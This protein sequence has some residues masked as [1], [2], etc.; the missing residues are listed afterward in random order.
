MYGPRID[1]VV[2]VFLFTCAAVMLLVPAPAVSAQE[3][4]DAPSEATGDWIRLESARAG[5]STA[6]QAEI[7]IIYAQ[8][9][10]R[11]PAL[12]RT[13]LERIR[14]LVEEN[15]PVSRFPEVVEVISFIALE[16]HKRRTAG[17]G[18]PPPREWSQAPVRIEAV[19]LL[20][21]IGGREAYEIIVEVL[22]RE[23]DPSVSSAALGALVRAG[24]R[25]GPEVPEV[26]ARRMQS[27][28]ADAA[29]Q[30]AAVRTVARLHAR[31]GFMDQPV[32]FEAVFDVAQGPYSRRVRDE[33]FELIELLRDR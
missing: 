17:G 26:I 7:R 16:P 6:E 13:A 20:G 21:R 12:Q 28:S 11:L 25:P 5:R 19:D 2:A 14:G 4:E 29:S 10:S 15:A 32:L 22:R 9:T 31:Y 23:E 1:R 30:L 18:E 33:A 27:Q 8:A 3:D 24:V